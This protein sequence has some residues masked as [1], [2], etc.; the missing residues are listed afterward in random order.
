MDPTMP[1]EKRP[2][3]WG[4]SYEQ[5]GEVLDGGL[6]LDALEREPAARS[7]VQAG[8][9]AFTISR[10]LAG[11]AGA[12]IG[13]P[14]GQAIA[15]KSAD[16]VLAGAGAGILAVAIPLAI[17]ASADVEDAVDAHNRGAG[18]PSASSVAFGA[19]VE[20]ANLRPPLNTRQATPLGPPTLSLVLALCGRV[21]ASSRAQ[22]EP[23]LRCWTVAEHTNA[24][25]PTA[26]AWP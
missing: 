15:G 3:S 4:Y 26:F 6:M 2:G 20:R 23:G 9:T 21:G 1:I 8:R 12:L 5:R 25:R 14:V 17:V 11:L 22:V 13:W 16:W 18:I 10:I 24:L 19:D 7:D